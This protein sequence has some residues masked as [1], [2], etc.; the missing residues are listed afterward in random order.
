[1]KTLKLAVLSGDGIGPEVTEEAL[2]V[3]NSLSHE[4]DFSFEFEHAD[5]GG[6]AIDAT[7]NPFP[8]SCQKLVKASDAVLLGAVGGPKW[9]KLI[10]EQRPERGLLNLRGALQ[11]YANLRPA[12]FFDSLCSASPLRSDL[13]AD[14][15]FVTVRELIGGIYFGEPRGIRETSEGRVGTNTMVYHE[16]E[17]RRIGRV[18]FETAMGRKKK[19]LSVDKANVLEVQRLWREVMTDLS[20]EYPEVELSHMYV[21]NCAMQ[22][23]TRPAQLDVLVTGNIFGDILS[24]ASAALTGSL[25]MLPSA[26]LGD[27]PGI[28]EP[29]HGTAPD[30]AGQGKANPLATILSVS[31][32]LTHTAKR[33]DLAGL[34]DDAVEAVLAQGLR[35]G[36]IATGTGHERMVGTE[37]MGAAVVHQIR[38]L[39]NCRKECA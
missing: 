5:F 19:L 37:E 38:T 24:D 12:R 34:V 33:P 20:K 4:A 26:S 13:T 6:A 32:L 27:G 18:A 3:L 36:D 9:D 11:V 30:I 10:G 14:V 21:D 7:G 2:K 29:V 16:D 35:T 17:I 25:G 22:M 39:T 28:Y 31:M 15:D 23:V 8:E 1:M